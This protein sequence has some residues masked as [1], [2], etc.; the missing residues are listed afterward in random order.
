MQVAR[1][2]GATH[3]KYSSN[4]V[5]ATAYTKDQNHL[6]VLPSQMRK[7]KLGK[8]ICHRMSSGHRSMLTSQKFIVST[9]TATTDQRCGKRRP[10]CFS[11][12]KPELS[13]NC[14]KMSLKEAE[15]SRLAQSDVSELPT[16]R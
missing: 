15:R 2:L 14:N 7:G 3:A 8:S 10:F 16:Q 9:F 4:G 1:R 13:D 11:H 5:F 6:L 12:A